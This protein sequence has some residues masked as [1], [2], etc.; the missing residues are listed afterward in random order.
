VAGG[1]RIFKT[2][3]NDA[4]SGVIKAYYNPKGIA[5]NKNLESMMN[6]PGNNK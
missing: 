3:T 1:F 5:I 2:S 4:E 6:E